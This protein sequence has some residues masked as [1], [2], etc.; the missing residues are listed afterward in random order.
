ML[1]GILLDQVQLSF[2]GSRSLPPKEREEAVRL[3][4]RR[5][6]RAELRQAVRT[7]MRRHPALLK[8]RFSLRG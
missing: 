1:P 7:I 3:L 5:S 2:F 6:F 8:V 4:N